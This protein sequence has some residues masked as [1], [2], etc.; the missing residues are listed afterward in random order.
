MI[1]GSVQTFPNFLSLPPGMWS[2]GFPPMEMDALS[3]LPMEF[4][5]RNLVRSNAR[6]IIELPGPP[7][8]DEPTVIG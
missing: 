2:I 4:V 7:E 6:E 8:P 5:I 1:A 3:G